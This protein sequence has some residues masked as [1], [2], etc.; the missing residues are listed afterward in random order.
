M[1]NG[2]QIGFDIE[3]D[4]KTQAW[5]DWVAPERIESQVNTFVAE[6]LGLTEIGDGPHSWWNAPLRGRVEKAVRDVFPDLDALTSPEN[7]N[8]ADQFVCFLGDIFIRRTGMVWVNDPERGSLL[9]SDF[10]PCVVFDGDPVSVVSMARMAESAA[11]GESDHQFGFVW[12]ILG[13]CVQRGRR[14]L[15]EDI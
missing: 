13:N 10:G 5:L 7:Q 3:F 6:T 8:I 2:E 14:T 4:E 12:S 1:G 11:M 15:H 9:Y